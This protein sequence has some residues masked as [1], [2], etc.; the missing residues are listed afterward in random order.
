M[1][2]LCEL[3]RRIDLGEAG[4][5]VLHNDHVFIAVYCN[6]PVHPGIPMAVS[7]VHGAGLSGKKALH[8][9]SEMA[10]KYPDREPRGAGGLTIKDHWH[11]HWVLKEK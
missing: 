4:E 9:Y 7:R 5:E 11:E 3:I 6:N 10:N 8:V 2:E 1:C